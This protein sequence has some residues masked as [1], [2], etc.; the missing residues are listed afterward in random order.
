VLVAIFMLAVYG[1]FGLFALLALSVN[2]ILLFGI[3]SALGATLT[4]PGIA[5]I[6]LTIGMAVDSNVVIFER[7]RDEARLGQSPVVAIDKGFSFALGT[8]MDANATAFFTALV[9]YLFGGSGP[10]RGFA[11]TFM[12]GILTTAFTAFTLTRLVISFWV[13]SRRPAAIPI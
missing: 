3:Q 13:R 9:L 1:L 5:G 6:I 4:L 7:I 8:I 11:V 10:V 2:V 12:I